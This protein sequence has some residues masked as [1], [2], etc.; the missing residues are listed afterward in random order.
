MQAL[1]YESHLDC[2]LADFL[3]TRAW[4]N[5]RIGHNLF[6]HL[7]SELDNPEVTLRFGLILETYLRG[8]PNHI[9]ELQKQVGVTHIVQVC[10]LGNQYIYCVVMPQIDGMA[11]M[12][13]ITELLQSKALKVLIKRLNHLHGL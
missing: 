12:R 11:K 9:Y 1:K 5:K 6:W 7:K 8:S 2:P 4:R 10:L 3:L 13:N